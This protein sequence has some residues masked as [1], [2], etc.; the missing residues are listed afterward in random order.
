MANG[1]EPTIGA[2]F[3]GEA[4]ELF[5]HDGAGG[6]IVLGRYG[7]TR[8]VESASTG[9]W[10]AQLGDVDGDGVSDFAL[11]GRLWTDSLSGSDLH[12]TYGEVAIHSGATGERIALHEISRTDTSDI[13]I[14][15][16]FAAGDVDGDGRDDYAVLIGSTFS[17]TGAALGVE[18]RSGT[19]GTLIHGGARG[20][21]AL[22]LSGRNLRF[23][24]VGDLDG[25]GHAD[26]LLGD[27]P[28]YYGG[29]WAVLSGADM[30]DLSRSPFDHSVGNLEQDRQGRGTALATGDFDGDGRLDF[31]SV[32]FGYGDVD[33]NGPAR[34]EIH[35]PLSG[36]QLGW[37][38]GEGF[39][40]SGIAGHGVDIRNAGD[41]DGDG[42]DDLLVG[43]RGAD[44]AFR[45]AVRSSADGAVIHELDLAGGGISDAPVGAELARLAMDVVGDVNGDGHD[46]IA[47]GQDSVSDGAG[48]VLVF[49]GRDGGLLASID[50]TDG[51]GRTVAAAGDVDGDGR[52]DFLVG[53]AGNDGEPTGVAT[54]FLSRFGGDFNGGATYVENGAPVVVDSDV[55]LADPGFDAL[56]DGAGDWGGATLTLARAGGAS[57]EDVFGA[58][59]DVAFGTPDGGASGA[60]GAL[61]VSGRRIGAVEQVAGT[62]TLSIESG[63][64][65]AEV[66]MALRAVTYE[67]RSDLPPASVP[68]ELTVA[69]GTSATSRTALVHVTEVPDAP[70]VGAPV[71]HRY[72]VP[73]DRAFSVPLPDDAFTDADDATLA[74]VVTQADGSPLP[75]WIAFDAA[76]GRLSGTPPLNWNGEVALT[77][78]ASDAT[79][80][81][82]QNF[83]LSVTPIQTMLVAP[84]PDR[85]GTEDA[86]LDITLPDGAFVDV[87]GA[88]LLYSATLADGSPL[89]DW[90][91]CDPQTGSLRGTPPA[92]WNGTISIR[93]VADSG[94][95][96]AA[97]IFDLTI[98][99]VDDGPRLARNLPDLAMLEDG[100]AGFALPAGTFVDVEGDAITYSAT[101]ADGSPLPG[102]LGVVAATG[103][104]FGS[105]EPDWNGTLSITMTASND[106]GSVSDT[107]DLVVEPTADAIGFGGVNFPVGTFATPGL[108]RSDR[109]TA[110]GDIDGDGVVD[111]AVSGQITVDVLRTF[112][113][114]V[115]DENGNVVMRLIGTMPDGT[116]F[117]IPQLES[118]QQWMP[119]RR[120]QTLFQSGATGE[121]IAV[122]ADGAS[123][124]NHLFL[125]A[126]DI[127]GDGT[128]DISQDGTVYSGARIAAGDPLW[129]STVEGFSGLGGRAVGVGDVDGDGRDDLA[130][131]LTHDGTAGTQAG[132]VRLVS[133]ADGSEIRTH[134]GSGIYDRF[135]TT[136]VAAGDVNGDGH[137]DLLIGAPE[138]DDGDVYDVGEARLVS[139]AD[140]STL[141]SFH[142]TAAGERV[143][144]ALAMTGDYDGD[145]AADVLVGSRGSEALVTLHSGAT[146][147]VLRR[148]GT[149][150]AEERALVDLAALGDVD[151][152][153]V[154]DLAVVTA[155]AHGSSLSVFS[156]ES[157]GVL[158]DSSQNYWE[159]VG[160]GLL[161]QAVQYDHVLATIGGPDIGPAGGGGDIDGDG[162]VD[163]AALVYNWPRQILP[164]SAA[165]L[166]RTVAFTEGGA[167]VALAPETDIREA[168]LEALAEGAGDWGGVT[169]RFARA[170]EPSADDRFVALGDLAFAE[171]GSMTLAGVAVGTWSLG[172]DGAL[173]LALAAGT[174]S[175]DADAVLRSVGYVNL[176]DA[177]E[178]EIRI[179]VTAANG[180]DA[181]TGHVTVV[182]TGENDAPTLALAPVDLSAQE[183]TAFAIALPAGTFADV[184][185]ET[186]TLSA[187]LADGSALPDW[188][189]FDPA[190]ATFSGTPPQDWNGSLALRV[191][192]TDAGGL[193]AH[194][195]LSLVVAEVNDAPSTQRAQAA[196]GE[197]G[198]VALAL[199]ETPHDSDGDAVSVVEIDGRAIAPGGFIDLLSGAR[200]E[201]ALDGTFHYR[202]N[203][204]FAELAGPDSG[205][206]NTSALDTVSYR[207]SD[208]RGG[209]AAGALA[210]TVA[211]EDGEGDLVL[212]GAGDDRLAGGAGSDRIVGGDGFDTAFYDGDAIDFTVASMGAAGF[213][214]TDLRDGAPG[215]PAQDALAPDVE[216]VRFSDG[217]RV[218][219]AVGD[220][221]N[222]M[223][224]FDDADRS[225]WRWIDLGGRGLIEHDY[226]DGR[227]AGTT[228]TDT[229]LAFD[230]TSIVHAFDGAGE[231]IGSRR[232]MDDGRVYETAFEGGRPT[233]ATTT[234]TGGHFAWSRI[235]RAFDGNG[236]LASM[237]HVWD[238]GRTTERLYEAGE[239]A[240]LTVMPAPPGNGDIPGS[241][242][243]D[244]LVL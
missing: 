81:A 113:R 101:L 204:A 151:G 234:D 173:V 186:P 230:W 166:P 218:D 161:W 67:S 61:L 153:G 54:L 62:L 181:R 223:A 241:D 164:Q 212:G 174:P 5:T 87:E 20:D 75:D 231:R 57:D 154:D 108:D 185:G 118:Y 63:A 200:I 19:D 169:L 71:P 226:E 228:R 36:A 158:L 69:N 178:A 238:D 220:D 117:Y 17:Q 27:G 92:D 156:G 213:T 26:F 136:V 74:L 39:E 8:V 37:F 123:G 135:G 76:T 148:Y 184:D 22:V 182:I 93:L 187:L 152:D 193:E 46:D 146:G 102:T 183:D 18:I 138:A 53:A 221:G 137:A 88:T 144:I 82:A 109:L 131:A 189:A 30:S 43:T 60:R 199:V 196:I 216:R 7:V 103:R 198:S 40:L 50:G 12:P 32:S 52:D 210:V 208:G 142:G 147:E 59:G 203:G 9:A 214:V 65:R 170:G 58:S 232:E 179:A 125:A 13:G 95:D 149:S 51:F 106:A 224:A 197:T 165:G 168:S 11:S 77:V 55:A 127:D 242:M 175:A 31:A 206:V 167:P 66:E 35:D 94:A 68:L 211:G 130:V 236:E 105:P 155:S 25:D 44:G 229:G 84:L 133:G 114:P 243:G 83:T 1:A 38:G 190:T 49:S 80:S 116:P 171:G 207:V 180:T 140:G 162:L 237:T 132:A 176:S 160:D 86:A 195:D 126:G 97:D 219:L 91:G 23:E 188:L 72:A 3:E 191:V 128:A 99:P 10:V 47:I 112:S 110:I 29:K 233:A 139:G 16:I 100:D 194:A 42:R 24:N 6:E 78:T 119:E 134:L 90:I 235:E 225:L 143:G 240:S 227:L 48:R 201:Q 2:A 111:L 124:G 157:T 159:R 14:G 70:E 209:F 15:P 45:V 56:A 4:R 244:V 141:A 115:V 98:D 73:Q 33:G 120:A 145:G 192:A 121:T 64:T 21:G 205:A 215:G 85:Q 172:A 41:M 239:L 79:A 28:G 104:L 34:I 222:T 89:P 150:Q 217:T 107:F 177:P 202:T 163:I 96:R 129:L 122:H